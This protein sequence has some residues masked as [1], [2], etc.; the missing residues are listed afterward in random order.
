MRAGLTLKTMENV[1]GGFSPEGGG[2]AA[3]LALALDGAFHLAFLV[4]FGR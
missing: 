4:H 2:E 3:V 1:L